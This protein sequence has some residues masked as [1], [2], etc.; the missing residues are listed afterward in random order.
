[1]AGKR[2]RGG[3]DI[4]VVDQTLVGEAEGRLARLQAAGAILGNP[5]GVRWATGREQ[6][7]VRGSCRTPLQGD[8]DY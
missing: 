6:I 8:E 1:M 2:V 7:D 3:R 4:D 5:T